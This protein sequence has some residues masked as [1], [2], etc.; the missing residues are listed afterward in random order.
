MKIAFPPPGGHIQAGDSS[1]AA[2][3]RHAPA[4]AYEKSW[5]RSAVEASRGTRRNLLRQSMIS[6]SPVIVLNHA[7]PAGTLL[8][9]DFPGLIAD[10][11]FKATLRSTDDLRKSGHCLPP[12]C[13]P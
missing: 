3:D 13:P 10:L 1:T 2:S 12:K 11:K 9:A 8:Q 4:D 7:K 5:N 6:V